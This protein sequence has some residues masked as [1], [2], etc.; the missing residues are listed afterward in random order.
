MVCRYVLRDGNRRFRGYNFHGKSQV[1]RRILFWSWMTLL[2]LAAPAGVLVSLT[3][4]LFNRAPYDVSSD[5]WEFAWLIAKWLAMAISALLVIVCI[6]AALR[7]D[8][9]VRSAA[10]RR[11]VT[12]IIFTLVCVVGAAVLF[13]PA[14]PRMDLDKKTQGLITVYTASATNVTAMV[15]FGGTYRPAHQVTT[16]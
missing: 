8:V 15:E 2:V 9:T 14:I 13:S 7:V 16:R 5:E 3:S 10:L 12:S 6:R 4:I 11:M 1:K